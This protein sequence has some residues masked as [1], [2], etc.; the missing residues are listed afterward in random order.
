M[1]T[2]RY[3]MDA[4]ASCLADFQ[5]GS[6]FH[7]GAVEPAKSITTMYIYIYIYILYIYIYMH[8]YVILYAGHMYNY[9]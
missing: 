5:G 8:S 2:Y 4:A 6:P 1:P 3:P 9:I 7:G